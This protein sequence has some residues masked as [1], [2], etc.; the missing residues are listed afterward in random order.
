MKYYWI[1]EHLPDGT[2][3]AAFGNGYRYHNGILYGWTG[4]PCKACNGTGEDFSDKN[5]PSTTCRA[6]AG[7]GDDHGPIMR[8]EE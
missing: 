1:D 2:I 8:I 4:L 5:A 3:V 7:T 6:C